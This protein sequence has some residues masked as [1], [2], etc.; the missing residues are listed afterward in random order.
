VKRVVQRNQSIVDVSDHQLVI[1][2]RHSDSAAGALSRPAGARL[3]DQQTAHRASGH[4]KEVGAVAPVDSADLL[5][6]K[7]GFMDEC[8]RRDAVARPLTTEMPA[9]HAPELVVDERRKPVESV[10][11]AAPPRDQQCRQVFCHGVQF[12][13]GRLALA[14]AWQSTEERWPGRGEPAPGHYGGRSLE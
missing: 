1:I 9:C 8:R 7:E 6:S 5:Q 10:L 12:P 13:P 2:E 4:R 3:V 11:I 14:I